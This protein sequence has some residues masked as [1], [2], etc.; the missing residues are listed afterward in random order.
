MQI[1]KVVDEMERKTGEKRK[2]EGLNNFARECFR[3]KGAVFP[4]FL[5]LHEIHEVPHLVSLTLNT[6]IISCSGCLFREYRG[7]TFQVKDQCCTMYTCMIEWSVSLGNT[8]L[9]RPLLGFLIL[10]IANKTQESPHAV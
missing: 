10:E 3:G 8:P 4:L 7:V 1:L 6:V 9:I 2:M 5:L